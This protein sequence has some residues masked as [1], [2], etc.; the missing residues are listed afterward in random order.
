VAA[1][2]L[3]GVQLLLDEADLIPLGRAVA[4]LLNPDSGPA[5]PA[6]TLLRRGRELEQASA[7]VPAPKQTAV[8]LLRS[9]YRPDA[10]GV[11][12]M[13]R[14]GD[15]IAEVDRAHPAEGPLA[16]GPL[17]AAD[18]RALFT[19]TGSFLLDEQRGL[20]RFLRIVQS[21]CLG[22][23]TRPGCPAAP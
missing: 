10:S 2:A 6:V 21:R 22:G 1:L 12:P 5:L 13:S 11:Y 16:T 4:S 3:D 8:R 19:T 18:Y 15:A 17:T 23:S 9:L 20:L 14:L 7:L